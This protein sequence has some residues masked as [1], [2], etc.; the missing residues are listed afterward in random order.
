[1]CAVKP[2]MGNRIFM[3]AWKSVQLVIADGA[4]FGAE[5]E[6]IYRF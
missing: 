5:M 1:M 6:K 3:L 4:A 2:Q